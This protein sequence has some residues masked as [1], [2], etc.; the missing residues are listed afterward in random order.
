MS[1]NI[2]LFEVKK[3]NLDEKTD[4]SLLDD[5]SRFIRYKFNDSFLKLRSIGAT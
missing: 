4:L 1:K 2:V 5:D 3:D